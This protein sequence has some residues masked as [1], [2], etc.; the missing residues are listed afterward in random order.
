MINLELLGNSVGPDQGYVEYNNNGT[1]NNNNNK[2][3]QSL[4]VTCSLPAP[5]LGDL[6]FNLYSNFI[7]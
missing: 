5:V 1:S 4:L 2:N 6:C 3:S 7:K